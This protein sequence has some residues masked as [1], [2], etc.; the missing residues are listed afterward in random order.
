MSLKRAPPI[1]E[2]ESEGAGG[3]GAG[4]T[5]TALPIPAVGMKLICN[6][7]GGIQRRRELVPVVVD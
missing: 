6:A 7:H 5:H 4:A 3:R 1:W 2:N